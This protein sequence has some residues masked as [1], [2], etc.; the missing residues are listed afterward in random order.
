MHKK[1]VKVKLVRLRRH[2]F[3]SKPLEESLKDHNLRFLYHA[4]YH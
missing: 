3:G 4:F 1:L 2:V